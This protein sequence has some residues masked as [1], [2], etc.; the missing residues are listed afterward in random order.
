MYTH[1]A[2][3]ISRT[4]ATKSGSRATVANPPPAFAPASLAAGSVSGT[5]RQTRTPNTA[6]VTASAQKSGAK[7]ALASVPPSTIAT[8]N[9]RF[10]AQKSSP[11]ARV[12]SAA[13]TM[14]ATSADDAGRYMS[15]ASP[16]AAEAAISDS[17]THGGIRPR[18]RP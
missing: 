4:N 7:P 2:T 18:R 12:L 6:H 10:T 17:H 15:T 14:S 1:S 13:G 8:E 3:R 5:A 11:Y 16:T 9:P